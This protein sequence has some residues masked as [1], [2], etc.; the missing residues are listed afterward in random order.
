MKHFKGQDGDY[1]VSVYPI[2]NKSFKYDEI[3]HP[4]GSLQTFN[5]RPYEFVSYQAFYFQNKKRK[6]KHFYDIE[7][8]NQFVKLQTGVDYQILSL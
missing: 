5:F 2:K 1:G 6:M 8:L 3:R 4:D 7:K